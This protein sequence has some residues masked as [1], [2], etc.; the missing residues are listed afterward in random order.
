MKKNYFGRFRIIKNGHGF[1]GA[2]YSSQWVDKLLK[3][4]QGYVF[5]LVE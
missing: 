2:G 4:L 5:I 1:S 3:V